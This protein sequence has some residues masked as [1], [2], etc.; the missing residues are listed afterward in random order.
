MNL[1]S[2]IDRPEAE[3]E[4]RLL[5]NLGGDVNI[6]DSMLGSVAVKE[7]LADLPPVK[8]GFN[9]VGGDATTELV[10]LLAPGATLVTYGGMSRQAPVIPLDLLVDRQIQLKGFWMAQWHATHTVE[11]QSA[12]FQDII[13]AI[14]N[15]QLAYFYELHDLDDLSYALE[16]AESSYK[17]RKVVLNLDYPDRLAEHDK[18]TEDDYE[19][20]RYP[21]QI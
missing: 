10:R 21:H 9:G 15:K 18:L 16:R 3:N 7:I 5:T 14:K 20:F 11:E 6:L 19:H 17:F 1:S 2:L 12:M 8:L 13:Q 4:L